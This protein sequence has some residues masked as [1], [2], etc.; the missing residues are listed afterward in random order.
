MAAPVTELLC[1]LVDN[2]FQHTIGGAFLVEVPSDGIIAHLKK[3]VK[4]E[5]QNDLALVDADHLEVWRLRSPRT[6]R[7]VKR[8]EYFQNLRYLDEVP[9]DRVEGDDESAWLIPESDEILLHFS[10]LP[11]NKV[12]VLVQMSLP[13]QIGRSS[14]NTGECSINILTPVHRV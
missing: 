2:N 4:E 12:S 13:P 5:K 10:G 14:H 3:K 11:R 6:A 1:I 8:P 9:E 7:E